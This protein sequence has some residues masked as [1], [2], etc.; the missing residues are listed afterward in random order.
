MKINQNQH[1]VCLAMLLVCLAGCDTGKV[2]VVP[3]ADSID[4][5][6]PNVTDLN[7]DTDPDDKRDVLFSTLDDADGDGVVDEDDL[8]DDTP[9]DE[10]TDEFGCSC[11]QLDSDDDGVNDCDDQCPNNARKTVAGATIVCDVSFDDPAG[12]FAEFYPIVAL[13]VRTACEAW[14]Q[15]MVAL[16]DVSIEVEVR[17][18]DISTAYASS[19]TVARVRNDN[20]LDTYE[21]GAVSEIRTGIDP[22][23]DVADAVVTVGRHNLTD[24]LWWFDPDPTRREAQ[25]PDDRIDAYSAF[26]HEMGH[27]FA[28]NGWKDFENGE[29]PG[30]YLS[31][32]DEYIEF[33]GENFFFTG[34]HAVE[35]YGGPVPLTYGNIAHLANSAPR[36]GSDLIEELMNGVVT[37][38]GKR[39]DISEIDLAILADV[40]AP[41][42]ASGTGLGCDDLPAVMRP[43][44]PL[45]VGPAPEM[46]ERPLPPQQYDS[47]GHAHACGCQH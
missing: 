45:I 28:Y 38:R 46:Q 18:A 3:D 25:L 12:E 33:D 17:F 22:N 11:S 15:H 5:D 23:D 2:I 19:K 35:A 6:Q 7:D 40:G 14:T 1:G 37:R 4:G 47:G 41:V 43:A 44:A 9:S 10:L 39:R 8:C 13:N 26:L 42:Q 20:G 29:L 30:N 24:G 31:T 27:V 16:Q 21:Q 36:P 34:E 32:F